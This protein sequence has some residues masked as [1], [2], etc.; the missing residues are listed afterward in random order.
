MEPWGCLTC[1]Y[2]PVGEPCELQAACL[3]VCLSKSLHVTCPLCVAHS[4]SL[5]PQ[6]GAQHGAPTALSTR[7]KQSQLQA[8]TLYNIA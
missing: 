5:A 6:R 7:G 4:V 1:L 8:R 3:P 2:S